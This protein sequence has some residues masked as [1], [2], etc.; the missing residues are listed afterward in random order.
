ML[1]NQNESAKANVRRRQN[2]YCKGRNPKA[3]DPIASRNSSLW[4]LPSLAESEES[5]AL[6]FFV[7][8][9]VIYPRD[10]QADRGFLEHLPYLFG[11]LRVGS[12]LSL[13]LTAASRILYSK[14]ERKR[15]DVETLSYPDYGLAL[16]STRRALEDPV[17]SMTDQTLMAVCLLGFYEVSMDREMIDYASIARRL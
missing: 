2:A 16:E 10:P 11:E 1:R 9:F 3:E 4:I 7:S 13:A 6:S 14:W 15:R 5:H 12:P 17:E 8:T